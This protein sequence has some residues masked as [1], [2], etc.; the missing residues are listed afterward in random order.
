MRW[1]KRK[2]RR[3]VFDSINQLLRGRRVQRR[4]EIQATNTRAVEAGA[5]LRPQQSHNCST[6][7][8][9]FPVWQH[10]PSPGLSSSVIYGQMTSSQGSVC[11]LS[12]TQFPVCIGQGSRGVSV[13][14]CLFRYLRSWYKSYES[15]PGLENVFQLDAV[16]GALD[17]HDGC[18]CAQQP[19]TAA[20]LLRPDLED[21]GCPRAFHADDR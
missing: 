20:E 6:V 21:H 7:N 15:F 14:S 12:L 17:L 1:K 2:G 11:R 4:L 13:Q 19:R 10:E 5:R 18:T 9:L 16:S 3:F 8:L